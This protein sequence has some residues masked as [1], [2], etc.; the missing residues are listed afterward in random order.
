MNNKSYK[1]PLLNDE[2]WLFKK[3]IEEELS[4]VEMSKLAGAKTAN[5]VR[6]ALIRHSIPVRTIGDGLRT[7]RKD[8]NFVA[9]KEVIDGCLLGDG[10][11]CKWNKKSDKS[12]PYFA[13][14]NKYYDHIKYVAEIL[15]KDKW[16][17]RVKENNESFL[18]KKY[19]VFSLRSLS[20]KS[21]KTF[22][23]RWY[24]EWN[25]YKKIIPQDIEITSNL[26]LHWFLDDGSSYLR[27]RKTRQVIITFCSECFS[28]DDQ[29]MIMDKINSKFDLSMRLNKTNS[30]IGYRI[31]VPQLKAD[32]FYNIIGDCPVPSM[33]YKWK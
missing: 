29:E 16:K 27:K 12:L 5:S 8:D 32:N 7:N 31:I 13:K 21:L 15:F 33:E 28:K 25:N 2:Q 19:V 3:Y 30:G 20:N 10:F 1:Y 9:N 11:L 24:P 14:R 17:E 18:G 22:Y 6:Q 23:E 26:L 4:T